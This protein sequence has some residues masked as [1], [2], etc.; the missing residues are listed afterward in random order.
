MEAWR[1]LRRE[2]E[3]REK[4]RSLALVRQLAGWRF[5]PQVG[6][7]EQLIKYEEALRLYEASSGKSFPEDLVLATVLTGLKEPLR[8]N[9]G[10]APGPATPRCGNG[11]CS[12]SP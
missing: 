4:A 8:S 1:L 11:S 10:W 3:P 7:H 9:F 12:T 5:D 2:M 6:L